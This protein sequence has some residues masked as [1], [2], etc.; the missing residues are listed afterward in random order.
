VLEDDNQGA[1]GADDDGLVGPARTRTLIVC[2]ANVVR[3]PVAEALWRSAALRLKRRLPVSS[4][5]LDASPGAEADPVCIDLMRELSLDLAE[6]R[7]QR[8]QLAQ[9]SECDLVLVMENRMAHRIQS[10]SPQLAGRVHL[11][12]RWGVGEIADPRGLSRSAYQRTI[13]EIR[14]SVREWLKRVP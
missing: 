9:A 3:S 12:G 2:T 8:F 1:G 4:V 6:H 10:M 7:S 11:L 14:V 5:G 13:A